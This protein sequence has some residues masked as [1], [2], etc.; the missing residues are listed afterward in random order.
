MSKISEHQSRSSAA[1]ICYHPQLL[2]NAP[3]LPNV[4]HHLD[5]RCQ[6]ICFELHRPYLISFIRPESILSKECCRKVP[7]SNNCSS[8]ERQQIHQSFHYRYPDR[9]TGHAICY[10]VDSPVGSSISVLPSQIYLFG[11]ILSDPQHDLLR[12]I[13]ST[14]SSTCFARRFLLSPGLLCSIPY[15]KPAL[16]VDVLTVTV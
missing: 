3:L 6:V 2:L 1:A 5:K 9:L 14:R 12:A 11:T 10:P 16:F 15:F 13:L 4:I 7:C 8:W